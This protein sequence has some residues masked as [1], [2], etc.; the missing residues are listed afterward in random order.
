METTNHPSKR[1]M[2]HE[3]DSSTLNLNKHIQCCDPGGGQVVHVMSQFMRGCTY[4][5]DGFHLGL[6]K[7]VISKCQ[8]FAVVEDE[9]LQDLFWM[10][11]AKVDIPSWI[12]LAKDTLM[13][14]S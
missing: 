4:T 11:H 3:I 5:L 9:E 1:I 12:T 10:L 7:W 14:S 13:S 8:P 6:V 2:C